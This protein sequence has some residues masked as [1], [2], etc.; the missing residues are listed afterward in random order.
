MD[1]ATL[2][3][4]ERLIESC[5]H[6]NPV[7]A[8]IPFDNILDHVT[9][10]DPSVTDY[11][12]ESPAKCPHCRRE[13]MEKSLLSLRDVPPSKSPIRLLAGLK[14]RKWIFICGFLGAAWMSI[15]LRIGSFRLAVLTN[16]PGLWTS[17]WLRW[18]P[19]GIAPHGA[20]VFMF[21]LWMVATSAIEW[22]VVGLLLRRIMQ[23]MSNSQR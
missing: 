2:R 5:E 8:E 6:C 13:I 16:Y 20:F 4:T 7:G 22:I 1:A 18:F 10:P 11:I 9:G 19:W 3:E 15:D 23:I 17:E 12:L 21:N 14:M